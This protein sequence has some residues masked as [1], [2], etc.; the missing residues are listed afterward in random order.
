MSPPQNFINFGLIFAEQGFALVY[1]VS[2]PEFGKSEGKPDFMGPASIKLL[3]PGFEEFRREPFVDSNNMG[4][5]G[6]SRGEDGS[7]ALGTN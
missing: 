5:F 4:I 2:E 7:V 1:L 3:A 6:F